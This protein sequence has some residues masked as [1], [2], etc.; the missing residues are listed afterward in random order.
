MSEL[1][2]SIESSFMCRV[3]AQRAYIVMPSYFSGESMH[4]AYQTMTFAALTDSWELGK[5]EH[6]LAS[7]MRNAFSV[8]AAEGA[9]RIVWRFGQRIEMRDDHI[10][11]HGGDLVLI[12]TRVIALDEAS[13]QI[14]V[15]P[16]F[17]DDGLGRLLTREEM[18][19]GYLKPVTGR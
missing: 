16:W 17:P 11:L 8:M 10:C 5:I 4:I 9:R 3:G 15:P 6:A 13:K 12:R 14:S 19:D 7:F 2:A 1:I 18:E